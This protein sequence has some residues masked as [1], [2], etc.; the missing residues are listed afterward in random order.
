MATNADK[1]KER[2]KVLFAK[3]LLAESEGQKITYRNEIVSLNMPLVTTVLRKYIPYTE[4][5]FQVGCLGLIKAADT[6]EMAKEVPFHNY[7]CFVIEREL[8]MDYNRRMDSIE[9]KMKDKITSLDLKIKADNGDDMDVSGLIEDPKAT[10]EMRDLIEHYQVEHLCDEVIRPSIQELANKGRDTASKMDFDA[11]EQLEF[12]YVMSIIF[13]DVQQYK[14]TMSQ[15]AKACNISVPNVRNRHLKVMDLIFQR[16]WHHMIIPYNELLTRIRGNYTIPER[17]LCMDP[18]K[19]TGWCLF[20]NGKLTSWGQIEDCYDDNNINIQGLMDLF[21]ATQPTF[22]CYEDY[23][24]YSHKLDRH[25]F[26]PVMTVRLIG[27][28]ETYCQMNSISSHKQMASTAKTFCTDEKMKAWGFWQEGMRHAR[29][30][31][32]HGCYF[33]LFYKKGQNII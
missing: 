30:A 21:K 31:I 12:R 29:D 1:I 22:I 9:E 26:S 23:R 11:W 6:Y 19:T 3:K 14:F 13:G 25:T 7:A 33:L 5:Q 8:H 2:T 17:L 18:G 32:R 16:M 20:T 4:D 28:I 10:E 24:V 27:A 15:M